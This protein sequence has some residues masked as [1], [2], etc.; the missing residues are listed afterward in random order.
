MKKFVLL[1][2]AVL[3]L[4]T[5]LAW[6]Q[7]GPD[8][9]CEVNTTMVKNAKAF[10]AA[11]KR[12]NEFHKA[13]KGKNGIHVWKIVTGPHTGA[14]M[15][16]TCGLTW[17]GLDGHD[18]F[19]KRDEA[20]LARTLGPE[21]EHNVASYYVMQPEYGPVPQDDPNLKFLTITHI[22]IKPALYSQFTD[23]AKRIKAAL[24]QE[25][26]A[27]KRGTWYVLANG[28]TGP[29]FV[30]ATAR[31]SWADMQAPDVKTSDILKKVYGADDK[32]LEKYREA[33]DH[34]T[35]EMVEYRKDLSYIPPM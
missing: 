8:S 9:V 2:G 22:F 28:G 21:V 26:Y 13:E 35:S 25:K 11:R 23:A 1:W 6:A 32:T 7:S 15:T 10:E 4:L 3:M 29:E 5:S 20:D 18:E 34:F 27:G 33:V 19:D 16:S 12:H 24:D 30:V 31:D 17:K 14:Y